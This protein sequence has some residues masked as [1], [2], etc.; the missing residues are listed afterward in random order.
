ME[1]LAFIIFAIAGLLIV[2]IFILIIVSV[3]TTFIRNASS[4]RL[5]R[6]ARVIGKRLRVSGGTNGSSTYY[7]ATFEFPDGSREEFG[8]SSQIYGMIAEGDMG[9]LQS[10]GTYMGNFN[11]RV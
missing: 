6:E 10:Q 7:Y 5:A 3:V 8:V 9:T 1:N 4:P 2:G 11:R